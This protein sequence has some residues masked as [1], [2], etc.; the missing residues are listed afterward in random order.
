MYFKAKSY[1]FL[2]GEMTKKQHLHAYHP[3]SVLI[4]LSEEHVEEKQ[5][6]EQ[7]IVEE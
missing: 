5:L 1:S 7:K 2:K 4:K 3:S 6:L